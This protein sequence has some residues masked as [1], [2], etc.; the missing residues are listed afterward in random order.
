MSLRGGGEKKEEKR[1][2][3]VFVAINLSWEK[4]VT[5]G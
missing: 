3:V 5:V 1:K 4:K 2:H